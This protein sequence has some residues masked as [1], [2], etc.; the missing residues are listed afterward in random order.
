LILKFLKYLNNR[1][2]FSMVE[3]MIGS[4]ILG[5]VALGL[6]S[7]TKQT[8]EQAV[9]AKVNADITQLKAE[10]LTT[11]NKPSNC[12]ANFYGTPV[13]GVSQNRASILK[14]NGALT[15]LTVSAAASTSRFLVHTTSWN[16]AQTTVSDR[17]RIIGITRSVSAVP[18]PAAGQK[19]ITSANLAVT[20]ERFLKIGSTGAAARTEVLNFNV[21][22]VT[23]PTM[24]VIGCP[25]SWNTTNVI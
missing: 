1:K 17:I 20:V 24:L 12:N 22:V 7:L 3:V 11:L 14:C 23:D 4:G 2:G 13:N 15:C 8:A 16:P 9:K 10:I 25:L 21:P 18:V 5:V 6:T 19:V